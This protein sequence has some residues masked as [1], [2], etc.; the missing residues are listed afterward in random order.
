MVILA[1][2]YSATGRPLSCKSTAAAVEDLAKQCGVQ[3]LVTLYDERCT[4]EVVLETIRRTGQ[5]CGADDWLIVYFAGHGSTPASQDRPARRLDDE[6]PGRLDEVFICVDRNGNASPAT[7]LFAS[8]LSHAVLSSCRTETR[9]IFL[10]D[11]YHRGPVIEVSG[12]QWAGRQV[13]VMSGT[14]DVP[15]NDDKSRMGLFTHALLL[16]MDKLSRIGRE[17]YSV[18]L[19]YN[20]ALHEDELVFAGKQDMGIETSQGLTSDGM[21]WPL[22]PPAGYQAPLS[23]CAGPGGVKSS[24][25]LFGLTPA[26]L[27][28]VTQEAVNTPVSVEEY[29]NYVQGQRFFQV[30]PCRACS[31]GCSTSPC[32]IQ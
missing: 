17:N 15:R 4:K 20:A 19:L 16:A 32:A 22:V 18:G 25:S 27:S 7:Q 13:C 29:L 31:A 10:V 24:A 1:M 23:R 2:D 12:K 9:I 30:K 8:E 5:Q 11:C 14:Q 3:S 26:L 28:H 6:E 21:A